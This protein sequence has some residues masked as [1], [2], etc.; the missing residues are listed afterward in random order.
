MHNKNHTIGKNLFT[1]QRYFKIF[2]NHRLK[3]HGLNGAQFMILLILTRQ[4]GVSQ[5]SLNERLQFDKGFIAK[6]AKS[7][8]KDGY[9]IRE[10]ND[11][12]RRAY[13][14]FL[15]DKAKGLKSMMFEILDEWDS[16]L[17]DGVSDENIKILE[18]TLNGML[19]RVA[20]KCKEVKEE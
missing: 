12:D 15:T 17:L 5:E 8:E 10:V 11:K 18:N 6:V 16:T 14:L 1:V 7:L 20:I 9:I 4:D 3:E 19:R 13:K 2:L